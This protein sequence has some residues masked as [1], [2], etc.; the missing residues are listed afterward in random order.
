VVFLVVIVIWDFRRAVF[1]RVRNVQR[2]DICD[3]LASE[4]S[5]FYLLERRYPKSLSELES[6]F[7]SK[8]KE[9]LFSKIRNNKYQDSY[10]YIPQTNSFTIKVTGIVTGPAAIWR[11]KDPTIEKHYRAEDI[12]NRIRVNIETNTQ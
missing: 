10:D 2:L 12:L 5:I 3:R 11:E 1:E 4:I 7:P 6:S 9:D 8:G